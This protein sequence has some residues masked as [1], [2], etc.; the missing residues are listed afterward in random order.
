MKLQANAHITSMDK[1][2]EVYGDTCTYD[3]TKTT[4]LKSQKETRKKNIK[5]ASQSNNRDVVIVIDNTYLPEG[6]SHSKD[7]IVMEYSVS[8]NFEMPYNLRDVSIV[9]GILSMIVIFAIG[10]LFYLS[11]KI[12][13]DISR[14][15]DKYEEDDEEEEDEEIEEDKKEIS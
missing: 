9:M 11:F 13:G 5:G 14:K 10:S 7:N 6:G 12:K 3:E 8:S 4:I 15:F 2:I 1:W